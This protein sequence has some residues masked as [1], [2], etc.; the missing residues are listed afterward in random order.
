M[1]KI[2]LKS[3][4]LLDLLANYQH[5][6]KTMD[7]YL[8]CF[9]TENENRIDVYKVKKKFL[10]FKTYH[11]VYRVPANF[12]KLRDIDD[13]CYDLNTDELIGLVDKT[14]KEYFN[15]CKY[16][17]NEGFELL[18]YRATYIRGI[19]GT[20]IDFSN[21]MTYYIENTSCEYDRI[22]FNKALIPENDD[23]EYIVNLCL[24]ILQKHRFDKYL[25]SHEDFIK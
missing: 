12:S 16:F 8:T 9:F 13:G 3:Y 2:K 17:K 1:K 10:F 25:E 5:I 22:R 14:M 4:L 23:Y 15:L 7:D 6:H 11:L 20:I 18:D 19:D 24:T 21:F